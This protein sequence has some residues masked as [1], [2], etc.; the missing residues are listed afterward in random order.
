MS[1]SYF[2]ISFTNLLKMFTTNI[3]LKRAC[4]IISSLF[5]LNSVAAQQLTDNEI[6]K[7]ITPIISPLQK[8]LQL[9]PASYE[10]E[11]SKFRH[12]KLQQGRQYGFLSENVQIVFP[13]LVSEKTVSYMFAKNG[14]RNTSFKIID[15]ASLVPLLVASIKEQQEQIEKLKVAIEELKSNKTA[16][17]N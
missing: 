7:N 2:I 8:L 14:Y 15:E 13:E 3:I 11:T 5:I 9:Q 12:L 16:A 4:S 1:C 10:F 17:L 6:K